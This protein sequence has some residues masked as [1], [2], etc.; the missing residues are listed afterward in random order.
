MGKIRVL[1]V[2]TRLVGRGVPRHVL[3]IVSRLD[4]ERYDVEVLAGRSEPHEHG[5]WEEARQLGIPAHYV[6]SLKR[7][8]G[9]SA[10]AAFAAIYRHIRKG[11][12]DIVHTHISTAGI[13]GR[14]AANVAGV[15]AIL[16]T[17][18]G[19]LAELHDGSLRS[20]AF[21]SCERY[22]ARYTDA[23]VAISGDIKRHYLNCAVGRESQYHV[24]YN[25]IDSAAFRSKTRALK[26]PAVLEG[27]RLVGTVA[28]L[29]QEKGLDVLVRAMPLLIQ[30]VPDAYLC[31]V[32]VGPMLSHLERLVREMG[33]GDR[34]YLPGHSD[35]IT[36]WMEAFQVFVL[37]SISDGIPTA[38]LEAMAMGLPV[39]ASRVGGIPE[40]VSQNETGVLVAPGDAQELALAIAGVLGDELWGRHL[41]ES[42][43]ERVAQTFDL[44]LMIAQLDGLYGELIETKNAKR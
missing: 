10:A 41:G 26:L 2:V 25:A 5:L 15:P 19:R 44:D 30:R 16:H 9:P 36:S 37:P 3:N 24:I 34:V 6:A 32:G 8:V 13:L 27:K 38:I 35:D 43:R 12:Y 29:T 14:L 1:Q 11:R 31:I 42:G 7:Q 39:V 20:R 23:I 21:L 18:H 33:L 22:M 4:A 17:Y 28:S 40:I